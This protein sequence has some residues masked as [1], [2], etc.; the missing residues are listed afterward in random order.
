MC[1]N[2]FYCCPILGDYSTG[3][4]TNIFS[5]VGCN[6]HFILCGLFCWMLDGSFQFMCVSAWVVLLPLTYRF[7][8]LPYSQQKNLDTF[9]TGH[10]QGTPPH[11]SK[12]PLHPSL[13]LTV[14]S[15]HIFEIYGNQV[16]I[17]DGAPTPNSVRSNQDF[18]SR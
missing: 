7:T 4:W 18:T 12:T 5:F 10:S 11:F 13:M 6:D 1:C 9:T 16:D 2:G 3:Y 15:R 8:F 17:L 14:K